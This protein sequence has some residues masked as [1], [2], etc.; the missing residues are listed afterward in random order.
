MTITHVPARPSDASASRALCPDFLNA[1]SLAARIELLKGLGALP[2][3]EH[4]HF[5]TADV[6]RDTETGGI[7]IVVDPAIPETPED[8]AAAA[9]DWRGVCGVLERYWNTGN[10]Q[11]DDIGEPSYDGGH[12]VW[13]W[14][15]SRTARR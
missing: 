7:C 2:G 11:L 6:V 12:R 1:A 10:R 9:A 4:W 5:R 15:L 8:E 14:E 13:V 3:G